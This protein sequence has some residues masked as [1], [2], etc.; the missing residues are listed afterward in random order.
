[1]KRK[2]LSEEKKVKREKEEKERKA[3]AKELSQLIQS[4]KGMMVPEAHFRA[5]QRQDVPLGN[6]R[7]FIGAK[8]QLRNHP[9]YG[10]A[11]AM[12]RHYNAAENTWSIEIEQPQRLRWFRPELF[13]IERM[14]IY[15]PKEF[16]PFVISKLNERIEDNNARALAAGGMRAK[17]EDGNA[18]IKAMA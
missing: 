3:A 7:I 17:R 10:N 14:A 4:H 8:L 13:D 6:N 1:M 12:F 9:V 16:N 11:N 5:Q 2:G 15:N 18:L